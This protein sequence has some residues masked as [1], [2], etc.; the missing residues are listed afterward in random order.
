MLCDQQARTKL[1][2]QKAERIHFQCSS[3]Y[4]AYG[5]E[6]QMEIHS[7][8]WLSSKLG[9]SD[10]SFPSFTANWSKFSH[11]GHMSSIVR[12]LTYTFCLTH[13]KQTA[14]F[15]ASKTLLQVVLMKTHWRCQGFVPT[16]PDFLSVITHFWIL[17]EDLLD[18]IFT[19][20]DPISDIS[21]LSF[22]SF[23]RLFS[24]IYRQEFYHRY[25]DTSFKVYCLRC[26][27]PTPAAPW[28]DVF[29]WL[30]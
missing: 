19:S 28:F 29:F 24:F 18:P 16:I 7:F 30:N 23:S 26:I 9:I 20:G 6:F 22:L 8:K 3:N 12:K 25:Y 21:V 14:L 5:Q 17:Q 4:T 15:L 1:K 11:P 13:A 27:I 10:Y 2:H